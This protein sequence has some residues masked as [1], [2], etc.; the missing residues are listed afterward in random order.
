MNVAPLFIA[1]DA[2]RRAGTESRQG[3]MDVAPLF[4]AGREAA[5]RNRVPTGT[6]EERI[7]CAARLPPV[8]IPTPY[9]PHFSRP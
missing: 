5:G 3:Q 4:I 6:D 9:S 1:G 7:S 8:S 2:R